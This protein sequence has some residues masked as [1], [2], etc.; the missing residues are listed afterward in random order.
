M[1]H[2]ESI[3][4]GADEGLSLLYRCVYASVVYSENFN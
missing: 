1:M 2:V 4:N 3:V